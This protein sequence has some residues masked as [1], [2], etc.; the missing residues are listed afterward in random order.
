MS[1]A[2][3]RILKF[4]VPIIVLMGERQMP[5]KDVL[6]LVPGMIMELPKSSDEPLELCVNNKPIGTGTAVKVGE[7]FGIKVD[8]IGTAAERVEAMG[9]APPKEATAEENELAAMAEQ[10]LAGQL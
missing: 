8:F 4:D 1:D 5:M 7:N 10:M 3:S 6:A 9:K 2:L